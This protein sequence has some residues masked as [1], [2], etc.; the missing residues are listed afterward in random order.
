MKRS[1]ALLLLAGCFDNTYATPSRDTDL[2]T[3]AD[4]DRRLLRFRSG[5]ERWHGDPKQV[6]DLAIRYC[7]DKDVRVPWLADPFNPKYYEVLHKPEWGTYVTR[8][9]R[10]PDGE[11]R[12]RVKLRKHEEIW[13]AVQVSRYKIVERPDDRAH[14]LDHHH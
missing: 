3:P 6:A 14:T 5:E 10:Y 1:L 2:G 11:M 12:Y 13:Y 4:L 8:G 9:Y 7:P